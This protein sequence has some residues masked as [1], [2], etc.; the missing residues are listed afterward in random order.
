[1]ERKP[2]RSTKIDKIYSKL[3]RDGLSISAIQEKIKDIYDRIDNSNTKRPKKISKRRVSRN[4]IT[5]NAMKNAN[6]K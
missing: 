6:N 5:V 2:K 4:S 1:M 3:Q